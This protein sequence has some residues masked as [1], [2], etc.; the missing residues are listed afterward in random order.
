MECVACGTIVSGQ[1]IFCG[2]C[3]RPVDRAEVRAEPTLAE[4]GPSTASWQGPAP[5]GRAGRFLRR[6]LITLV[7]GGL[8]IGAGTVGV[9]KWIEGRNRDRYNG[10]VDARTSE[11]REVLVSSLERLPAARAGALRIF[12]DAISDIEAIEDLPGAPAGLVDQ[13]SVF[14][15]ARER[16]LRF[17]RSSLGLA[18]ERI[19]ATAPQLVQNA[20]IDLE[21]ASVALAD[22]L[23]LEPLP[24]IAELD[25]WLAAVGDDIDAWEEANRASVLSERIRILGAARADVEGLRR[26]YDDA[27][28]ALGAAGP[29]DMT[30]HQASRFEQLFD[31]AARRRREVAD[32]IIALASTIDDDSWGRTLESAGE[33]LLAV[34]DE[35]DAISDVAWDLCYYPEEPEY[36]GGQHAH[37]GEHPR[38]RTYARTVDPIAD[39]V[40][41]RLVRVRDQIVSEMERL[42]GELR[43]IRG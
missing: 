5:S 12:E 13:G 23:T 37:A 25:A 14:A 39:S 26:T 9:S 32:A 24:P 18:S 21:A 16:V 19:D 15:T 35:V 36:C 4:A 33:D 11:L 3:G 10:I 29:R 20:R 38:Y 31:S 7:V 6:A 22:L 42:R 41:A 34:A 27:R 1:A 8:L 30:Y 17:L 28:G 2:G 43:T 40:L